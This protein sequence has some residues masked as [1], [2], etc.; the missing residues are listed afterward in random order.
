MKE[1][2]SGTS[3]RIPLDSVVRILRIL[4]T[5]GPYLTYLEELEKPFENREDAQFFMQKVHSALEQTKTMTEK[6]HQQITELKG[7]IEESED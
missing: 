6:F 2:D 4:E 3:Q 5:S 7:L 1:M